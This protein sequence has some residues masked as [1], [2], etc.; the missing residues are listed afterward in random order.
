MISYHLDTGVRP[1][2]CE[3]RPD[4]ATLTLMSEPK[5]IVLRTAGTNC[6]QETVHAWELAG[7]KPER[8]HV[9]E[10]IENPSRL[11]SFAILTIP[12]GFSYGDDISA[13]KIL[14]GQMIHH[15]SDALNRFVAAGKL[16]L[17]IC[18][19]FQVLVKAGLL[20]GPLTN[21]TSHTNTSNTP[22]GGPSNTGGLTAHADRQAVTLT[23]NDSAKFEDRWVCLK[24]SRAANAFV[25]AE[26]ILEMPIAH[27]EGKLVARDAAVR[28]L[29][30]SANRVA[31]TYCSLDGKP[32]PY[33]INP[34]G[35]DDDIAGL[36]DTTGR[37]LGLM[38]HPERF[39][40]P[41]QHPLWTRR[42]SDNAADGRVIFETAIQHAKG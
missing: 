26:T 6:D 3:P 21:T 14:A 32:G 17:G 1:V 19:G 22:T 24:S 33:P 16:V 23:H 38:P 2:I 40:H 8:V 36:F 11:D 27:G 9:R 30:T 31:F 42:S 29:L 10:L 13:G 37:V 5:V 15:L 25:P 20:P 28:Q 7:A 41:T 35:S 4:A 18:N 12:G 39:V 34:N